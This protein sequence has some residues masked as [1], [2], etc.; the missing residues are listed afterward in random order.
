MN[1]LRRPVEIATQIDPSPINSN[2][3]CNYLKANVTDLNVTRNRRAKKSTGFGSDVKNSA[4]RICAG[5]LSV[6]LKE[7]TP[8][9]D[10]S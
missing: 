2:L 9:L 1:V 4:R 10:P 3:I 7:F 6:R 5:R 8:R